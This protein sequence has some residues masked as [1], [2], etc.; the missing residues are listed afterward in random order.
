M[1]VKDVMTSDVKCCGAGDTLNR[2][3]QLMWESDCGCVPVVDE[4]GHVAAIVTDRD[5]CMAVYTQG[6]PL[7]ELPV[8]LAMSKAAYSCRPEDAIADAE[9]TMRE[10]QVRRLPVVD[11]DGKLVGILSLNDIAREAARERAGRGKKEIGAEEIATTLGAVC[12]PHAVVPVAS[13]A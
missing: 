3:A 12:E 7:S 13:A 11:A 6:R 9:E 5:A 10:H 8:S 1:H 4:A 2:A